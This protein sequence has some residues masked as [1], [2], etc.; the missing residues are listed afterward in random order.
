MLTCLLDVIHWDH[1]NLLWPVRIVIPNR[2]RPVITAE[3]LPVGA[4]IIA[5]HSSRVQGVQTATSSRRTYGVWRPGVGRGIC[6]RSR[7]GS[8]RR[9]S[10]RGIHR[11]SLGG[12]E[13]GYGHEGRNAEALH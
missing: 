12:S 2:P 1:T 6:R 4:E 10:W 7:E 13:E 5:V 8:R 3:H 9:D 11:L